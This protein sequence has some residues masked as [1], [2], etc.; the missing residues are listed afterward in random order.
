MPIAKRRLAAADYRRIVTNRN[1]SWATSDGVRKSMQS[2]KGRD[3][4]IELRVRRELFA[5]GLRYRVNHRPVPTFRRTADI[6]FT[7]LRLAVFIDGC[8]WHGCS[9]HY[10]SPKANSE[11]WSKKIAANIARDLDTSTRLEAACWTVMR[12]WEHEPPDSVVESIAARVHRP[13][14]NAV[15]S[16]HARASIDARVAELTTSSKNPAKVSVPTRSARSSRRFDPSQEVSG[17][18]MHA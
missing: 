6:V 16:V 10:T 3:T 14:W 11:F 15:T 2:N 17:A 8:F 12:F 7:R 13:D 9:Q 18:S 5:L 4:S 1:E